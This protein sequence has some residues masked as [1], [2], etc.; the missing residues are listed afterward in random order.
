MQRPLNSRGMV[1]SVQSVPVAE[2]TTKE[3]VI[4]SLSN[5]FTAT[6]E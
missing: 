2:H 4:P 5:N 1:F 3:Y 6:K